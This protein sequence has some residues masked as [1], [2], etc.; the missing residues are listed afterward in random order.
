MKKN[1]FKKYFSLQTQLFNFD[2]Q[3]IK[4]LEK[5]KKHIKI[6]KK[7]GKKVIIFGNGGSAAIANH[8]SVDLTK[9]SK[10]RCVNFNESSLLTCF[11]NDYGYENWVKKTLEF[12]ADAGDLIILISSKGESKNMINACKY[13]RKK[14]FFPV[15]TLTGF[16]K[17]NSLSKIGHINFWVN[18]KIYN[19]VENTHQ[20]LLLSLVDATKKK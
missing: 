13:L 6:T 10:I 5:V 11:S 12:H 2:N 15:I 17:N 9:I 19:H 16:K 3:T 7:R 14:R 1:F 20:L 8:F 4:N 18:S